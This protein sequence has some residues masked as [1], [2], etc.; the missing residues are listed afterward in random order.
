MIKI[1]NVSKNI[2]NKKILQNINLSISKGSIFGLIGPNG[3]GKT[4]LI[5][6][7]TGIYDVDNGQIEIM[8][9]PVFN[10]CS[11]KE[12]IAYVPDTNSF[13]EFH[14]IKD[15]L[16]FYKLTYEDFDI[17]KFHS[18]NRVF[19]IPLNSSL[20]KLSKG[21]RMRLSLLLALC[22]KPEVLILDE[23]LSGIDPIVKSQILK[24]LIEE[25]A[26][27]ETTIFISSHNL[28]DLEKICDTI[29]VMNNG[30]IKQFSSLD[31]M[32]ENFK[33]I[34]IVFKDTV[35]KIINLPGV[36][37]SNAI[38]RVYT[39]VTSQYESFKKELEKYDLILFEEID[40][41]LED[42]FIHSLGG[43]G[44]EEIL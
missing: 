14:K 9:Q 12:K 37:S 30:E 1:S 44:L 22:I 25:T 16:K 38:G 34:Q 18:I 8:E 19:N 33:K 35:P 5:K 24:L 23:P 21:I 39:I 4:T 36:I 7:L 11:I 43:D 32:K 27:R 10:N 20:K 6:C 28:S 13:F 15:V 29:A 42:I 41:S 3:A 26:E 31:N 2:E 40:L 17:E